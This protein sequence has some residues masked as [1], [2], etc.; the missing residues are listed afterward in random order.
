[1]LLQKKKTA[2]RKNTRITRSTRTK[3]KG[4]GKKNRKGP[5][6]SKKWPYLV[7][8]MRANMDLRILRKRDTACQ[9]TAD[10]CCLQRQ[11]IN[12]KDLGWNDW[13][14]SPKNY[15]A[16]YCAGDCPTPNPV[17]SLSPFGVSHAYIRSGPASPYA[18]KPNADTDDPDKELCCGP[19]SLSPLSVLHYDRE[20]KI[21]KTD[22]PNMS[23]DECGCL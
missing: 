21:V 6:Y 23:V 22:I 4:K 8:G 15:V 10:S 13:I 2:R 12:F 9:I 5:K 3:G 16:N 19:T 11:Y 17:D 14:I 20:G 7:L 1:M 18:R